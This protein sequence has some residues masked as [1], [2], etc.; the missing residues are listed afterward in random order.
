M[1]SRPPAAAIF[2]LFSRRT[3]RA[4]ALSVCPSLAA[5]DA[6]GSLKR[7]DGATRGWGQLEGG[8]YSSPGC[9]MRPQCSCV[10]GGGGTGWVLPSPPNWG[11]WR[12]TAEAVTPIPA[13]A[14]PRSPP[15]K[16][17][18]PPPPQLPVL[19]TAGDPIPMGGIW[20]GV[21]PHPTP[22]PPLPPGITTK[23]RLSPGIGGDTHRVCVG[24]EWTRVGGGTGGVATPVAV[25]R[26]LR[27]CWRG[28]TALR[29]SLQE[30]SRAAAAAGARGDPPT[31]TGG[32]S[33]CQA[34]PP[35]KKHQPHPPDPQRP[36][37]G[38]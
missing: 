26:G 12:G 25:G 20:G 18:G 34:S 1:T 7:R 16:G 33:F 23:G 2:N 10:L 24:G 35:K 17:E 36:E 31:A 30:R 27:R 21:P 3:R 8:G 9:R 37:L 38:R 13:R 11:G 22:Q 4:P 14:Q 15:P 19:G 6:T 28:T 29:Q 5:I 32:P